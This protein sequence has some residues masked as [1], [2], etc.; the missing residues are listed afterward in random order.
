MYDKAALTEEEQAF[1]LQ[2]SAFPAV[3]IPYTHIQ[4]LWAI[5]EEKEA[6]Y[7][8]LLSQLTAKGW[9]EKGDQPE[10]YKV[11]QVIG[12]IL[13]EGKAIEAVHLE[14]PI[15]QLKKLLQEDQVLAPQIPFLPYVDS[16][17]ERVERPAASLASLCWSALD[18][19][20]ALGRILKA[21]EIAEIAAE[22]FE[23]LG[24]WI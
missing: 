9:L 12:E 8:Q 16:L 13:R 21:L 2:L 1:L 22:D 7:F 23:R 6:S 24:R 15:G 10:A 18:V 11:H 20:L 5:E 17:V 4:Y 3:F 14:V 19:N